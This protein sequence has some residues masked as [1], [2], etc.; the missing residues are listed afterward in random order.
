MNAEKSRN[1]EEGLSDALRFL[2]EWYS[3]N[4]NGEWEHQYGVR[5]DTLDNPGWSLTVD[6]RGTDLAG[7]SLEPVKDLASDVDWYS[8]SI[9]D[10]KFQA[11]GGPRMLLRIVELFRD[12][13][14]ERRVH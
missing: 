5:I 10:G 6:L 11:Q 3:S 13:A 8:C 9:S 2:E 1:V 4:V 14:L 12:F 7:A